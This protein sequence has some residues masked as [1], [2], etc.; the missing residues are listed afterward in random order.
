M[1]GNYR[2]TAALMINISEGYFPRF[3]QSILPTIDICRVGSCS[4]E[5]LSV[6]PFQRELY[7]PFRQLAL[8]GQYTLENRRIYAI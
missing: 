8:E 6:P 5:V 3:L 4:H 7:L 2:C 1:H